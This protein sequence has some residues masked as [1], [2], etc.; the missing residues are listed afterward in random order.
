MDNKFNHIDDKFKDA[1]DSWEADFSP[2]E[3]KADWSQLSA[4]IAPPQAPPAGQS[5]LSKP[6][7]S[8]GK[9]L[10]LVS[11]AAVLTTASVLLYNTYIY[12]GEKIPSLNKPAAVL[13]NNRSVETLPQANNAPAATTDDILTDKEGE[14]FSGQTIYGNRAANEN[15][16]TVQAN[17]QDLPLTKNN[18]PSQNTNNNSNN[19]PTDLINNPNQN[20]SGIG[21]DN[22]AGGETKKVAGNISKKE[23]IY[24]DSIICLGKVLSV[25]FTGINMPEGAVIQWGDGYMQP[26]TRVNKHIYE[27]PGHFR[28]QIADGSRTIEKI[29]KVTELPRA[30]FSKVECESMK[31]K[32]RNTS[33]EAFTYVWNFGDGS[34]AVRA[35]HPEH[36]FSDT[37]RYTVTL[38]AYNAAGC[39]DSFIQHI[40][41][42][43]YKKP[44]VYNVLTPNGD[45]FNDRFT[46]SIENEAYFHIRILDM[47]GKLVF[48]SK[49]KNTSWDG[50]MF[51]QGNA[52][53]SGFYIYNIAYKYNAQDQIKE[54]MS[55]LE[56]RR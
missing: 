18:Q 39:V 32:F 26:F 29:I 5:P 19:Q 37:G 47:S 7:W 56:L 12:D 55:T 25:T 44:E 43:N 30:N 48:E 53:A 35:F 42:T 54:E 50:T 38:A 52:C 41:V 28:I 40:R 22:G 20:I 1:F 16:A 36:Q 8:A 31:C 45:G 46:V 9:M 34:P 21:N 33:K 14:A 3:M 2:A 6:F 27:R 11:S 49:D 4:K 51:N 17:K 23:L 24:S 13:E 10:G 15:K